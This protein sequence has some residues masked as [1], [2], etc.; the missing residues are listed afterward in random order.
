MRLVS[1]FVFIVLSSGCVTN[2][3]YVYFQKNDLHKKDLPKDS[4]VR[5]Y[6]VV[7]GYYCVQPDDALL[8]EVN[9]LTQK[10]FDFFNLTGNGGIGGGTGGQFL[11]VNAALVD[12]DG[13]IDFAVVGKVHV[14]GKNVFEIQNQLQSL[15]VQFVDA[16]VV[17]VR[18]VNFRFTVMGEVNAEGTYTSL[19]N[20]ISIPEAIGLAGGITELADRSNIKLIRRNNDKTEIIYIDLLDESFMKSPYYF[21]DQTD[22]I[23]VPSLRQRPFRRYF[24]QN[25][26]LVFTSLTLL[27]TVINL[28]N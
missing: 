17:K 18:H 14:A 25:I 3:K 12:S 19:N 16:P 15:A 8:I 26:S 28:S 22:I 1:L 20:R 4:I 7:K 5:E 11:A 24:G 27:L 9:S 23:I 6:N 10:E 21:V 13:N 2:K